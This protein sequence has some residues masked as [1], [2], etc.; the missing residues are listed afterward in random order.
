MKIL[1]LVLLLQAGALAA[2]PQLA[3]PGEGMHGNEVDA[4]NGEIWFALTVEGAQ[5]RL[6]R[7]RLKVIAVHDEIAGD[8]PREMSGRSVSAPALK[9]E[10]LVFLRGLP[11]REGDVASVALEPSKYMEP[12]EPPPLTLGN[13]SIQLKIDCKPKGNGD[14]GS[15]CLLFLH[16]GAQTQMLAPHSGEQGRERTYMVLFAGDLDRDGHIDLLIDL[17]DHENLSEPTLFLSGSAKP[18]ELVRAVAHQQTSGC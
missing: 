11:L 1:A 4:R 6:T 18:G 2:K 7:T 14:T 15:Q 12:E 5:A 3:M 8:S 16:R 10:P 13:E 9:T 17:S